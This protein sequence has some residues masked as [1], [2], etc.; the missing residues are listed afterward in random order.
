M[1]YFTYDFTG[2]EP[3]VSRFS[4]LQ[5]A[6]NWCRITGIEFVLDQ[7]DNCVWYAG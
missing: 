1:I 4:R 3:S 2:P 5:S 7:D 6:I